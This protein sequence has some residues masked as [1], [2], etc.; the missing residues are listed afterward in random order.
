MYFFLWAV[1]W[2]VVAQIRNIFSETNPGEIDTLP[3][4]D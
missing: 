3:K 2:Q 4:S 1:V